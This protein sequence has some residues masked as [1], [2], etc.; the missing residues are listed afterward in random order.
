[1]PYEVQH[2]VS[3]FRSN[4]VEIYFFQSGSKKDHFLRGDAEVQGPQ[5]YAS[6]QN[7]SLR[8]SPLVFRGRSTPYSVNTMIWV[9]LV[10]NLI[11]ENYQTLPELP[12]STD[13]KSFCV[14]NTL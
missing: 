14:V 6:P 7:S 9:I 8:L 2:I 4:V 5:R 10:I 11:D 1:M 13:K 12:E 3:N